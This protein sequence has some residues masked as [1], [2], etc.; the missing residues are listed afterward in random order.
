MIVLTFLLDLM[1][2]ANEIYKKQTYKNYYLQIT[3]SD[4][5]SQTVRAQARN[6][7]SGCN[8]AR[9]LHQ[10]I[11]FAIRYLGF[12]FQ[13][14]PAGVVAEPNQIALAIGHLTRDADLVA[15]EVVDLLAAFTFFIGLVADLCQ[16]LVG[17]RIDVDIGVVAV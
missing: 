13:A 6:N 17:I 2:Q 10:S 12:F 16:R 15:V 9:S 8:A 7:T 3:Q 5:D 14:T 11:G 1:D 4:P